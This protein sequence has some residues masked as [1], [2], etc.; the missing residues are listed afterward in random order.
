MIAIWNNKIRSSII[1][2]L[3]LCAE[4][5][6]T[7]LLLKADDTKTLVTGTYLKGVRHEV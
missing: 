3:G 7:L 1:S 5:L 4:N 6:S 2:A